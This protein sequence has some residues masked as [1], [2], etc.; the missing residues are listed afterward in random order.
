MSER[1][2]AGHRSAFCQ[3]R[4]LWSTR[5]HSAAYLS[6]PA[7]QIAHQS[8]DRARS[9]RWY[10]P[11]DP[12]ARG[13]STKQ[14]LDYQWTLHAASFQKQSIL[15]TAQLRIGDAETIIW[16]PTTVWLSVP[17]RYSGLMSHYVCIAVLSSVTGGR[18][19][20]VQYFYTDNFLQIK[21]LTGQGLTYPSVAAW[22]SALEDAKFKN[23][24]LSTQL[25][26]DI[27]FARPYDVLKHMKLTG[28][29]TNQ[30]HNQARDTA[31]QTTKTAPLFGQKRCSS[32]SRPIGNS[33]Q[34]VRR[35]ATLCLSF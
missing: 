17:M 32:L 6:V 25:R 34:G 35:W 29:S 10:W 20:A 26:F 21:A 16:R 2:K 24:Q 28:V 9:R 18:P 15:P 7:Y 19:A 33:S 30:T 8:Q 5:A 1:P 11:D 27:P 12:V 23:I 14:P 13:K 4:W 22:R 3:S 31:Q